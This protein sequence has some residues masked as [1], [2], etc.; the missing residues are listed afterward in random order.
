[1]KEKECSIC[2]ILTN[3]LYLI[4]DDIRV[5]ISTT[6]SPLRNNLK[7]VVSTCIFFVVFYLIPPSKVCLLVVFLNRNIHGVQ[8]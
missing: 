6:L 4:R 1:M 8:F 5:V 7:Q 3:P 2:S